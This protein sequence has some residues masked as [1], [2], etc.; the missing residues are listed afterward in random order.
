MQLVML[1]ADISAII[2]LVQ[3]SHELQL[4]CISKH[5]YCVSDSDGIAGNSNRRVGG[6]SDA[7]G[8]AGGNGGNNNG[9]NA[10]G[11]NGDSGSKNGNGGTAQGKNG[12]GGTGG[13]AAGGEFFTARHISLGA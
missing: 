2:K 9:N 1:A 7:T 12:N 10:N 11:G 5:A 4:H 8:G 3:G 6:G 13:N